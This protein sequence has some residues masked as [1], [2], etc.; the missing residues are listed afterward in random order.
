MVSEWMIKEIGIGKTFLV[1][2]ILSLGCLIYFWREMIE[3]RG[4]NR[5]QL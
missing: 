3:S 5:V 4:L 1:F 2:G